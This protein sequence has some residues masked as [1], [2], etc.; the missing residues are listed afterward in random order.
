MNWFKSA[1]SEENTASPIDS[2]DLEGKYTTYVDIRLEPFALNNEESPV[3]QLYHDIYE[4]TIHNISSSDSGYYWCEIQGN[5]T[6]FDPSSFVNISVNTVNTSPQDN[7]CESIDF[8]RDPGICATSVCIKS[9]PVSV[10]SHT[11][12]EPTSESSETH[13]TSI[14]SKTTAEPTSESSETHFTSSTLKVSQTNAA[15]SG[16]A[17]PDLC[18]MISVNGINCEVLIYTIPSIGVLLILAVLM[19]CCIGLC[20]C[21]RKKKRKGKQIV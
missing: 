1:N 9:T 17:P 4:L 19:I 3:Y 8:G 7:N 15:M 5:E 20:I 18:P 12:A 13:F 21:R 6:C 16:S 14:Y 2:E 11:T 10:Y